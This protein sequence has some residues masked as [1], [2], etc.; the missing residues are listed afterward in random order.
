MLS[1]DVFNSLNKNPVSALNELAQK[2]GKEVTFELVGQAK[3]GKNKFTVACKIGGHLYDA[4]SGPNMK[5]ARRDACE[6]A[7]KV[8]INNIT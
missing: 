7:L 6:A 1:A 5:E 3:G 8:C 2:Q 4:V